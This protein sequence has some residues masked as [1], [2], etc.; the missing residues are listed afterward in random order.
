MLPPLRPSCGERVAWCGATTRR[1]KEAYCTVAC[2]DDSDDGG[3]SA[4]ARCCK[5]A[6]R[7]GKGSRLIGMVENK[8]HISHCLAQ[9]K[10]K[11]RE[12]VV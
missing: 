11:V 1:N 8:M 3:G 12:H 5:D 7:P 4:P 6:S 10:N 2:D 9:E